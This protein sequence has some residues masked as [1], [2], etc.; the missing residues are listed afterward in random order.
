MELQTYGAVQ[1]GTENPRN[2]EYRLLAKVT[3]ALMESSP[4][5]NGAFFKAVDWNRRVWLTLQMDLASEDNLLPDDLKARLIS[6]A[7]W[8]DKHSAAVL[9]GTA[10]VG[11][12]IDVNRAIMEGLAARPEETRLAS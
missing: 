11:A 2:T 3:R 5:V 6:L 7:I 10:E 12:L 1:A 4:H 8:V 9:R